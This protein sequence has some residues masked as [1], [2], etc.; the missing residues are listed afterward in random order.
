MRVTIE[1]ESQ[2]EF[3]D[4]RQSLIKAIGGKPALEPRRAALKAQNEIMDF[5]DGRF[6]AM[7]DAIKGDVDALL[8]HDAG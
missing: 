1:A 5:W 6:K 2:A 7:L 4:K 3:D 8:R